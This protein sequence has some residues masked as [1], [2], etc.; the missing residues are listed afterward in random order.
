L[1]FGEENRTYFV[2]GLTARHPLLHAIPRRFRRHTYTTTLYSVHFGD[3]I[4]AIDS[5]PC[6]PEVALL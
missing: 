2:L 4:E 1:W 3:S 5:R 6:H